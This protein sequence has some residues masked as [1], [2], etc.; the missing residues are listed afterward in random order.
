[1]IF[2]NYLNNS[3]V[4]PEKKSY[5]LTSSL[6]FM[7]QERV[8]TLDHDVAACTLICMISTSARSSYSVSD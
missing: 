5:R 7:V 2:D 3:N 4:A 1:M 8:V 6:G